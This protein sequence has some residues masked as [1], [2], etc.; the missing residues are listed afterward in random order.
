[1]DASNLDE[2]KETFEGKI[3]GLTRCIDLSSAVLTPDGLDEN[4]RKQLGVIHME[5]CMVESLV[6]QMRELV[7]SEKQKL[8]RAEA[9]KSQME[10][11]AKHIRYMESHLPDRLPGRELKT[12]TS[13]KVKGRTPL[14]TVQDKS[15][16]SN[17]G[18]RQQKSSSKDK[19]TTEDSKKRK[20]STP[21]MEFVTVEEF[22]GV[23]KYMKGRLNYDAINAAV[24]I[25]NTAVS[26][27]YS[28]LHKPRHA[29][30]ENAMKKVR[31]LKE[32]EN[33]DTKGV[34]FFTDEDFKANSNGRCS[35]TSRSI[36][37]ILRHCG[38]LREI[39]SAGL[40]RYALLV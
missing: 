11:Q 4:C 36:F 40:T 33:K 30:G 14:G 16:H 8:Q 29:L 35:T 31:R 5:L 23:P 7:H 17:Q 25:I 10:E 1:M 28:L 12:S 2:L 21:T 19:E 22:E 38:R 3:A 37:T 9:L 6:G 26:A 24:E 39:R 34:F 15:N 27:R 13:S 18:T 32:Q 20:P